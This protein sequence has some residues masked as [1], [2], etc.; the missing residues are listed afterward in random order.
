MELLHIG[1]VQKVGNIMPS[2]AK[3]LASMALYTASNG[4]DEILSDQAIDYI[5]F[6]SILSK[7]FMPDPPSGDWRSSSKV[8]PQSL[9]L[10][11]SRIDDYKLSAFKAFTTGYRPESALVRVDGVFSKTVPARYVDNGLAL[12][13]SLQYALLHLVLTTIEAT[14]LL[15]LVVLNL[16]QNRLPFDLAHVMKEE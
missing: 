13:S 4:D 2:A 14:L 10:I 12:A 9:D 6:N 8:Q 11:N 5:N 7:M 3:V 16:K 15:V 1:E